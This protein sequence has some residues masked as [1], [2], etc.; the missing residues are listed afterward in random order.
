MTRLPSNEWC[1]SNPADAAQ[2]LRL[3]IADLA[4]AR[5]CADPERMPTLRRRERDL[6]RRLSA[7]E[8][9]TP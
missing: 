8:G 5:A 3:V 6:R 1:T 7:I 2:I 4:D 9:A